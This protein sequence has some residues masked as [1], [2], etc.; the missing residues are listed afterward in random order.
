LFE[1]SSFFIK[2]LCAIESLSDVQVLRY[3]LL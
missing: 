2:K 1:I 3:V